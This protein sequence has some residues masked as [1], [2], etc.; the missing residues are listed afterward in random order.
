[1]STSLSQ[2]GITYNTVAFLSDKLDALYKS[3]AIR[4]W[5]FVVHKPEINEATGELGKEHI[6]FW[7]EPNKRLD[8]MDIM[9]YLTELCPT[10]PTKPYKPYKIEHSEKYNALLYDMHYKPYLDLKGLVREYSYPLSEFHTHDAD[11]LQNVFD[12][13]LLSDIFKGL[14][15]VRAIQQDGNLDAL[16]LAG[17]VP[18]S[19]ALQYRSFI[20]MVNSAVNNIKFKEHV[21][22]I[23]EMEAQSTSSDARE[24]GRK[25]SATFRAEGD[26]PDVPKRAT[27]DDKAL[28]DA[29]HQL[30]MMEYAYQ[31]RKEQNSLSTLEQENPFS[32][33][34]SST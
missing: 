33:D 4:A 19:Q 20:Q 22:D 23:K 3:K 5:W 6:H 14:R 31:L 7:F 21:S 34:K 9:T 27:K 12:E 29:Y 2:G 15:T 8:V 26:T 18:I 17:G 13:A 10:N 28:K 25:P 24:G 16:V 30:E 11:W 1:M 32:S